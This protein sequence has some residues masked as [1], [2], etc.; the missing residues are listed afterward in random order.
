MAL[1]SLYLPNGIASPSSHYESEAPSGSGGGKHPGGVGFGLKTK[2]LAA[3]WI[4]NNPA[5]D[6]PLILICYC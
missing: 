5:A 1:E 2:G 6:R 3:E 4:T